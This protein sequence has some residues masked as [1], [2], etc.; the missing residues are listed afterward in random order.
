MSG[1]CIHNIRGIYGCVREQVIGC[2]S[3]VNVSVCLCLYVSLFAFMRV[4]CMYACLF[5]VYLCLLMGVCVCVCVFVPAFTCQCVFVCMC[6]PPFASVC[7]CLCACNH[8]S[9][10]VYDVAYSAL[11]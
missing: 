5:W 9:V 2:R 3:W 4:C 1:V 7:L 6:L 10:C 8:I 11:L